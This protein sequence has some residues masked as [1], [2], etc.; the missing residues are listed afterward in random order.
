MKSTNSTSNFTIKYRKKLRAYISSIQLNPTIGARLPVSARSNS[1]AKSFLN[2]SIV[3]VVAVILGLIGLAIFQCI[4]FT[5]G[6][7]PVP[8]AHANSIKNI[9]AG[10][11]IAAGVLFFIV[12]CIT[13]VVYNKA[14]A[15]EVLLP[16]LRALNPDA[17]F[18]DAPESL[19]KQFARVN[20]N[21]GAVTFSVT[22]LVNGITNGSL[23]NKLK[24]GV[25][26]GI[27][28]IRQNNEY[29]ILLP[30]YSFIKN[31]HII[32]INNRL[33]LT[34]I[35]AIDEVHGTDSNG[36]ATVEDYPVFRGMLV[37]RKLPYWYDGE[38]AIFST[39][40]GF[41][42]NEKC[43]YNLSVTT[44]SSLEPIELED[45]A[46]NNC[47]DVY[48][49]KTPNSR[50]SA[51]KFLNPIRLSNVFGDMSYLANSREGGVWCNIYIKG[52]TMWAA[53]NTGFISLF[54]A[55]YTPNPEDV[56]KTYVFI[57]RE[58]DEY[59]NKVIAGR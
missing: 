8:D 30:Q 54:D 29:G 25:S 10:C 40:Q 34:E 36:N 6:D 9:V 53:F 14:W 2:S 12:S 13:S 1:G 52:D 48:S 43:N 28:E 27:S 22:E 32:T 5:I 42:G 20:S 46:F 38:L 55:V 51:T 49:L 59:L 11:F 18:E 19:R 26:E 37:K 33:K 24:D 31:N 45:M 23:I 21:G 56:A 15:G 3:K 39:K 35:E 7:T 17:N 47:H 57:L 16:T 58:I 41:F 4:N 44:D 50:L